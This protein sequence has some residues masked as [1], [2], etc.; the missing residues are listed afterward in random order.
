MAEVYSW[1]DGELH[2]YTGSHT[3]SGNPIAY[4]QN[5]SMSRALTWDSRPSVSGTYRQHLTDKR[6]DFTFGVGYADATLAA[7][8]DA[9]TAVHVKFTH[10]SNLGSAGFIAY[11]ARLSNG[12]LNGSDGGLFNETYQG[13]CHTWS[14]F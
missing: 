8:L 6:A 1:P 14:A 2:V 7:L 11:S 4:V 12:A 13:F 9:T 3:A 10:A 5:V